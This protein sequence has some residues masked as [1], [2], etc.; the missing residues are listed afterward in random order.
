M[1]TLIA[2]F[3]TVASAL[4]LVTPVAARADTIYPT[5]GPMPPKSSDCSSLPSSTPC[6]AISPECSHIV[7]P[8]IAADGDTIELRTDPAAPCNAWYYNELPGEQESTCTLPDTSGGEVV[9]PVTG[10][11]PLNVC[12]VKVDTSE[13]TIYHQNPDGSWETTAGPGWVKVG[14]DDVCGSGCSNGYANEDE[15]WMAVIPP[16]PPNTEGKLSVSLSVSP[17]SVLIQQTTKGAVPQQV[18]VTETVT[19]TGDAPV[20]G[21]T[22]GNPL[23]I[24]PVAHK[25]PPSLTGCAWAVAAGQVPAQAPNASPPPCPIELQSG[26]APGSLGT[27]A[28]GQSAS[29]TFTLTVRGDGDYMLYGTASGVSVDSFGNS[30]AVSGIG[31]V[32]F[33]PDSQLL[34]MSIVP[35]D[36]TVSPVN[37]LML[38]S[39]TPFTYTL[40]LENRSYYRRLLVMPRIEAQGNVVGGV[41]QEGSDPVSPN[42]PATGDPTEVQPDPIIELDPRQVADYTVVFWSVRSDAIQTAKTTATSVG[43]TRAQVQFLQPLIMTLDDNDDAVGQDGSTYIVDDPTDFNSHTFSIDDS[44][45]AQDPFTFATA[46]TAFSNGFTT[47]LYHITTSFLHGVFVDLPVGIVTGVPSMIYKYVSAEAQLWHEIQ[48]NPLQQALFFNLLTN[49]VLLAY[50]FAPDLAQSASATYNTVSSAVGTELNRIYGEWKVGDWKGAIQDLSAETGDGAGQ[51]G[52]LVGGGAVLTKTLALAGEMGVL[53]RF[54]PALQALADTTTADTATGDAAIRGS[55]AVEDVQSADT[56]AQSKTGEDAKS[57]RDRAKSDED[58]AKLLN[59]DK[60]PAGM[61]FDPSNAED[62]KIFAAASGIPPE[63]AA[64]LA[65][66]AKERGE[67]L[68]CRSRGVGAAQ[69][70]EDGAYLKPFEIKAKNMNPLDQYLFGWPSKLQDLVVI[71][72]DLPFVHLPKEEAVARFGQQ[73]ESEGL[74]AGTDSYNGAIARYKTQYKQ[75]NELLPKYEKWAKTE[76][77]PGVAG[78]K[79]RPPVKGIAELSWDATEN[80][81]DFSTVPEYNPKSVTKVPFRLVG[82]DDAGNAVKDLSKARYIT[83]EIKP[84]GGKWGPITGDIDWL[85]FSDA[86]GDQL[87]SAQNI[88]LLNDLEKLGA[89]HPESASWELD[90]QFLFD[91]KIGFLSGYD[92]IGELEKAGGIGKQVNFEFAPDGKIRTV[93]LDYNASDFTSPTQTRVAW[94]GGYL[95]AQP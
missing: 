36:R 52:S 44:Q 75:T 38:Q 23:Q 2:V 67:I 33:T 16:P 37:P 34:V 94:R 64:R 29:S 66:L 13:D 58:M 68:V 15:T 70:L 31:K 9:V 8:A 4:A 43:G 11:E 12:K 93:V 18:S 53:S 40:H 55:G 88:G 25:K 85:S 61:T 1:R 92:T 81:R 90:G 17:A 22:V 5:P 41:V 28:P 54:K 3:V 47:A 78:G 57:L 86:S 39:G 27:L 89:Q 10:G 84:L 7:A 71:D 24:V 73:L 51:L 82:F 49:Q 56:I 65:E 80:P 83:P 20:S 79:V 48:G 32:E 76:G 14:I 35:G 63:E 6:A 30:V 46:T 87:S 21:V 59:E 72:K 19:D 60:L 95:W 69:R 62:L 45:P 26:P 42:P 77:R 74:A 91:A 50:R